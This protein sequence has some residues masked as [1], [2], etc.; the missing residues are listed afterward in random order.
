MVIWSQYLQNVADTLNTSSSQ[1]GIIMALMIT[2]CLSV[3][4]LLSTRG[5]GAIVTLPSQMFFITLFFLYIGWFPVFLG[6]LIALVLVVFLGFVLAK[7]GTG[8]M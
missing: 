8:V 4:V 7:L 2:I 6:S 1:A 3:L 5:K